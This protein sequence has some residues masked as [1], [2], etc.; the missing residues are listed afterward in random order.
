MVLVYFASYAY[1][2]FALMNHIK[3]EVR[4]IS[5]AERQRTVIASL[6]NCFMLEA[7]RQDASH[8]AGGHTEEIERLMAEYEE[9]LYSLKNGS[10]KMDLKPISAREEVSHLNETIELWKVQKPVLVNFAKSPQKLS[11]EACDSCNLIV[12]SNLSRAGAFANLMTEHHQKKIAKSEILKAFIIGF[13]VIVFLFTVLFMNLSIIKPFNRLG[14]AASEIEKGNF[15]IKVDAGRMHEV[16]KVG[17]ALNSMSRT[18]GMLVDEKSRHLQKLDALNRLSAAVNK[19]LSIGDVANA[20]LDE[21]LKIDQLQ[22]EKKGAIFLADNEKRML[23]LIACR[24]FPEEFKAKEA[25]IPFGECICGKTAETDMPVILEHCSAEEHPRSYPEMKN[26]GH[27]SLPLI[28]RDKLIGVLT[29]YPP[30]GLRITNEQ[31]NFYKAAADIVA[32]SLQNSLHHE[33]ITTL[34][35][36][37]ANAQKIA[38]LGS[39]AF[40]IANKEVTISDEA[41]H[42]LGLTHGE[43][44]SSYGEFLNCVHP[45]DR[46]LVKQAVKN[47]IKEEKPFGM[48]H[49]IILPNGLE[50]AVHLQAEPVFDGYGKPAG[51]SGTLEDI[52]HRKVMEKSIQTALTVAKQHR[53]K[54]LALLESAHSALKYSEFKDAAKAI[55]IQCRNLIGATAG[56][57]AL[58][59]EDKA[60]YE[61]IYPETEEFLDAGGHPLP[62]KDMLE[63][64]HKAGAAIYENNL[65]TGNGR[66]Y[67]P[68]VRTGLNNVLFAPL[69]V[70]GETVGLLVFANKPG[71]F[72][73]SDARTASEF[74]EI[75]VV[76]FVNNAAEKELVESRKRYKKLVES[77]TD[78]IYTVKV[79]DGRPVSTV[80]SPACLGVTGYTSQEFENEPLL[81]H[82]I[83]CPDDHIAVSKHVASVL[84]GGTPPSLEHRII[85][86]DGS[87]RWVISM[88]VPRFDERKR[89]VAY[90][91]LI[92]DITRRKEAE[93]EIKKHEHEVLALADS[94]NV[95][96]TNANGESLYESICDIVVKNFGLKLAWLGFVQENSFDI[97][98]VAFAG[99]DKGYLKGVKMTWNDSGEDGLCQ[100]GMAIKTRTS[101]IINDLTEEPCG[102]RCGGEEAVKRGYRS[103]LA[104]PLMDTEGAVKGSLCLYSGEPHF[105][106]PERVRLFNIFANHAA[107]SI[108]NRM[109]IENLETKVKERTNELEVAS[110]QAEAANRAKSEF[111]A[112]MSHELRTPLNSIIGFSELISGGMAGP[113]NNQQGEYLTDIVNSGKHLLNLINDILDLSKVEAGKMQIEP[114]V[115]QLEDIIK[116]TVLMFSEKALNHNISV[117][118]EIE[119]NIE[120]VAD[121]RKIRQILVNLL[122]N[123][124][125]FTPDGGAV[126]VTARR[127]S[128]FGMRNS[129]LKSEIRNPQFASDGNF[130][131]ISV[132]DTG[133]GI[134]HEDQKKLFKPFQQIETTL[135]KKYAGTG[136]GLNL[137]KGFVELHGGKIW[138]ESDEGKGSKFSFLIPV[139]I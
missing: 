80:H 91:G 11:R 81:W 34:A 67:L 105:F 33:H 98:P 30:P 131:E 134:S 122:S 119:K 14:K 117:K 112:N 41:C 85:R 83:T 39:W 15:D 124:F 107:A 113:L 37:L 62:V 25:S 50:R 38:H 123:A 95:I 90:D 18:I 12:N 99:V 59:S 26:H 125:K 40:D 135:S 126:Q 121:E 45:G 92:S 64:A 53:D 55:F 100:V 82:K 74:S 56:Y 7:M 86:K 104:V 48:D 9:I 115:F 71:S 13:F 72:T 61:V 120:M 32:I 10:K 138:V 106:T 46:Q 116:G 87:I 5:I 111:L 76:A 114:S 60:S 31:V 1:M 68:D 103:L 65:Q 127:I 19:S 27:I 63:T 51:L 93:D 136:L 102:G 79:Q 94:S 109:L 35:S 36:S 20:A 110:F 75:A 128:E 17:G 70:Q 24:G 16:K 49:R 47:S 42:I 118:S 130:V 58:A 78:Y 66:K 129:E 8:G 97:K 73:E 54:A 89:L 88:V 29:L 6:G 23:N 44:G 139:S 52:T 21:I 4:R 84:S 101:Q 133:I 77:V 132:T 22:I 3:K 108:E 2:D 69:S 43:A 28:S 96:L 137:C 57:I